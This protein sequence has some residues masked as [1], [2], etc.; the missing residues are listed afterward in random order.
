[1]APSGEARG[2]RQPADP[3]PH[4]TDTGHQLVT[5]TARPFQVRVACRRRTIE[6]VVSHPN[7]STD[8]G[9]ATGSGQTRAPLRRAASIRPVTPARYPTAPTTD[10]R[11][12][13]IG[14]IT[15]I[16]ASSAM[17]ANAPGSEP[18]AAH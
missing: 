12:I 15:Y 13:A 9:W 5:P 4:D 18:K 14:G 11:A 3:G 6:R 2:R 16:T 8:S 7:A 1:M 10:P 17:T